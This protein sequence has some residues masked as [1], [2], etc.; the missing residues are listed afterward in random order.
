[1][2]AWVLSVL[3]AAATAL[4]PA[5]SAGQDL[6]PE[7][8]RQAVDFV[9]ANTKHVLYHEIGHM[10]VH[11]FDLPVLG[12]EEDAVDMLATLT[13]LEDQ[14]QE[15][16]VTP[17]IDTADGWYYSERTRTYNYSDADFSG[18]HSLDIQRSF[19]ITCLVV[20]SNFETH[21]RFATRFGLSIDR[22]KTCEAD[23]ELARR[24]W[25]RMLAPYERTL[26][27]GS[28]VSVRYEPA[29]DYQFI[30]NILRANRVLENA[31]E[32]VRKSYVLP[33][34]VTFTAEICG[35]ANAFYIPG[36]R[37]VVLCYEWADFYYTLFAEHVLPARLAIEESRRRKLEKI[38]LL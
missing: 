15:G 3:A 28:D 18:Q 26:E 4:A 1:M 13:L 7:Q 36:D 20:G 24:S 17:L 32:R 30:S 8:H 6:P 10:Y 35:E 5:M 31:A 33:R 16:T 11:L 2:K 23:Y 21:S 27:T 19:T 37:E 12:K 14:V 22:Q 29:A 25:F 9:I 34:E 38:E